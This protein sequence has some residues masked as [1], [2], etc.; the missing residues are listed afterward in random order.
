MSA[1]VRLLA[2]VTDAFGAPGG[3]AQYNR[4]FLTAL[5][6]DAGYEVVIL[7]RRGPVGA[8]SPAR[9][10]TQLGAR[11]GRAGYVAAALRAASGRRFD[12]VFC[13]HLYAASLAFAAARLRRSRLLI[14]LHGI[15]AWAPP[16]PGARKAFARADLVLAVSRF[17]RAAALGWSALAPERIVVVPN[18]VRDVFVPGD[19]QAARVALGFADEAVLLSVGRLDGR[20]RYKGQDRVIDVLPGLI[21]G[22]RRVAYVVAGAGD[23]R[24]RL[25]SLA[26]ERGVADAVRFVGDV[27][28]DGLPL[29]YRAADLFVMPSTGEG[30]GIV[31]LEA[32]ACG[33]PAL[34]LAAGGVPD[35]LADGALGTLAPADRLGEAIAA[36]LDGPRPDPAALSAAV[37]ERFGRAPF[38][39]AVARLAERLGEAA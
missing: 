3:I 36:V 4:D 10:M 7:P 5:A 29:L 21:A 9:G 14:Q 32:M 11:P 2:L 15:D 23:D 31:F 30:F 1:P 22:G 18:T 27:G 6:E 19:R 13:G 39:R 17:T 20:E 12:F 8:H 16:R 35:A 38:R 28:E 37:A 26:S 33:T 34:G 25:E 24:A